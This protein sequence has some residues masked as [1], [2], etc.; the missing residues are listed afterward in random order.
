[1]KTSEMIKWYQK[2][3]KRGLTDKQIETEF[4][5]LNKL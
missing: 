1:M 3:L 5:K 4:L 2:Q